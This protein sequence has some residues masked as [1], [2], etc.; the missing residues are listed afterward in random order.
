M[1]TP[2]TS[3]RMPIMCKLPPELAHALSTFQCR[4]LNEVIDEII[5][6]TLQE[7]LAPADW[8]R[9]QTIEMQVVSTHHPTTPKLRRASV[10]LELVD[11]DDNPVMPDGSWYLTAHSWGDKFEVAY[12][13]HTPKCSVTPVAA[14]VSTP[15]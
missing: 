3:D 7:A 9:V 12:A 5:V 13:E 15:V 14:N 6:P 11:A 2:G 4:T 8:T 1:S 10:L